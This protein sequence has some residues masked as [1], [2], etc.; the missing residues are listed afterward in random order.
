ML[1]WVRFFFFPLFPGT[2]SPTC[3][4]SPPSLVVWAFLW[5]VQ[6]SPGTMASWDC[7]TQNQLNR[8][9]GWVTSVCR[10]MYIKNIKDPTCHVSCVAGLLYIG[11]LSGVW[12]RSVMKIKLLI[13]DDIHYRMWNFF[14][15][16][17]VLFS[18]LSN[19][20]SSRQWDKEECPP[21]RSF[22]LWIRCVQL[23]SYV[24][25]ASYINCEMKRCQ[26]HKLVYKNRNPACC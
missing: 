22:F 17:I 26:S 1:W 3:A 23:Q 20:T 7:C 4:T 15:W 16:N 10:T 2:A 14:K 21:E 18:F 11:G 19:V 6:A 24:I 5:W 25:S 9:Y 12:R 13:F 8:C